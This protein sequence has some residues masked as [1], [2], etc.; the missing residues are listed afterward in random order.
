MFS[1]KLGFPASFSIAFVPDR[2][3][4]L[5]IRRAEEALKTLFAQRNPEEP[6]GSMMTK[7]DV[8]PGEQRDFGVRAEPLHANP[9][10]GLDEFLHE[11]LPRGSLRG[12]PPPPVA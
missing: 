12:H 11:Q 3:C 6:E 5:Q 1:P 4:F 8:A 9:C 7:L 10:A 2:S